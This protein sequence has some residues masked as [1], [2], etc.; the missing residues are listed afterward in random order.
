MFRHA[1][2]V[3]L[4]LLAAAGLAF[5][6]RYLS[7]L[8]AADGYTHAHALLMTAWCGLLVAQPF[9]VRAR[10][11]DWHRALGR[12]SYALVPALA[13]VALLLTHARL[14][15]VPAGDLRAEALNFYLPLSMTALFVFAYVLAVVFRRQAALHARF[16]MCTPLS[17]VDPVLGRILGFYLPPLDVSYQLLT[18]GLVDL[19]LL[20]LIVGERRQ[21]RGR[22][23][24]PLMLGVSLLAHTLFFVYAPGDAW[25]RFCLWWR[26]LPLT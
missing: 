7:R 9:L 3:G 4:L 5:W 17:A 22:W 2:Y 21:A 13:I 20:A 15:A 16:M 10:R 11:L 12:L 19:I 8:P 23:A 25:W 1:G 24:F 18:F 26:W 6:P 14:R